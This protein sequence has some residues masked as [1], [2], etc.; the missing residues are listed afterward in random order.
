[1]VLAVG[2]DNCA[3]DAKD[4]FHQQVFRGDMKDEDMKKHKPFRIAWKGKV[5][6][7][8]SMMSTR[9]ETI[10]LLTVKGGPGCAWERAELV[11]I[12]KSFTDQ[13][14]SLTTH[15]CQDVDELYEYLFSSFGPEPN[16]GCAIA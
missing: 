8:I 16:S 7:V 13:G 11:N 14:A 4:A 15:H 9:G 6:Q 2:G 12:A 3:G 1:M 10:E 5:T